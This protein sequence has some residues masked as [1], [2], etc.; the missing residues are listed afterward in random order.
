MNRIILLLILSLIIFITKSNAQTVI[1]MKK[2]NGVYTMP[3]EVNGLK[4]R[5]IFD[6]GASDIS[7]GL[8]EAVFMI[9][10]EYL[11]LDDIEGSS[12]YSIANGN[13][14]EGTI[15]NLREVI[16]GNIVLNNIRASVIHN[17]DTPLLLGQSALNKLGKIEFNYSNNTL[18]INGNSP[19]N[20]P[21]KA[22]KNI[23][24]TS[25]G[26]EYILINSKVDSAL[27]YYEKAINNGDVNA[28]FKKAQI[29]NW[30]LRY[31]TNKNRRDR[32]KLRKMILD[33]Y[34]YAAD[35]GSVE[36]CYQVGVKYYFG[37]EDIEATWIG[38]KRDLNYS[39]FYLDYAA[40]NGKKDAVV[41]LQHIKYY[42]LVKA[43]QSARASDALSAM[44]KGLQNKDVDA[45]QFMSVKI[46]Q[47]REAEYPNY[48]HVLSDRMIYYNHKFKELEKITDDETQPEFIKFLAYQEQCLIIKIVEEIHWIVSKIS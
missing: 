21:V 34:I 7:I 32:R 12:Q 28:C 17:I 38:I 47:R 39:Q 13:I 43:E 8:T 20:L 42:R 27:F 45:Q 16:I 41:L 9:K 6:T 4:L 40:K 5:F 22:T 33:Y 35:N 14:V 3:C 1:E 29:L 25:K 37:K 36:A 44:G 23:D 15:I 11:R 30:R 46:R 18:I 48:S 24:Y 10:N 19:I 2:E 31:Y 26:D